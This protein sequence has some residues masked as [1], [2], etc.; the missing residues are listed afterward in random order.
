MKAADFRYAKFNISVEG[1]CLKRLGLM[2]VLIALVLAAGA[3]FGVGHEVGHVGDDYDP[4]LGDYVV[5][6]S[7]GNTGSLAS[8]HQYLG[9][10]IAEEGTWRILGGFSASGPAPLQ[11]YLEDGKG[12]TKLLV[13]NKTTGSWDEAK[14]GGLNEGEFPFS[15]ED[16]SDYDT[17]ASGGQVTA[18]FI[19]VKPYDDEDNGG[20]GGGGGCSAGTFAPAG[21]L[22]LAPLFL[23]RRRG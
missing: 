5:L 11:G 10:E 16:N 13:Y 8:D 15:I 23:L 12:A 3:A 22:L 7:G 9:R 18:Y 20:G 14:T 1:I 19:A 2:A 21:L 17:N 4:N 6:K